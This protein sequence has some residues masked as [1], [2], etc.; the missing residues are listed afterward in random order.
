MTK[1]WQQR[2]KRFLA[3]R[4]YHY[5]DEPDTFMG[6]AEVALSTA[7]NHADPERPLDSVK[8]AEAA[9][10]YLQWEAGEWTWLFG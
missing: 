8:P 3:R 2:F 1:D 9:K 10:Q 5:D 6:H 7:Q 4:H